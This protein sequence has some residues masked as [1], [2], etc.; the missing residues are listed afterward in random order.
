MGGGETSL[1]VREGVSR[2]WERLESE[3]CGEWGFG[4]V[5]VHDKKRRLM[6]S[7]LIL[8]TAFLK[9]N[10][11]KSTNTGELTFGLW[12]TLPDSAPVRWLIPGAESVVVLE[13]PQQQQQ[14]APIPG[15]VSRN[16][17]KGPVPR[18]PL[19]GGVGKRRLPRAPKKIGMLRTSPCVVPERLI[20][21][22]PGS[23]S[24]IR[25]LN[26][27]WENI[28]QKYISLFL[29]RFQPHSIFGIFKSE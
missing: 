18:D 25:H 3:S 20:E 11:D 5:C 6:P 17:T 10:R 14:H 12:N 27:N 24:A 28:K 7:Q 9:E 8:L 15:A 23:W 19:V 21:M 4:V 29:N 1:E 16:I 2:E 26:K 22:I 13:I